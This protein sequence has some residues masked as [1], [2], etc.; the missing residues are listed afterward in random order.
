MLNSFFLNT[1]FQNIWRAL[2]HNSNQNNANSTINGI[3]KLSLRFSKYTNA[4][5]RPP[6]ARAHESHMKILAGDMLNIRNAMST[7]IIIPSS[8]VA[9][10]Q[11]YAKVITAMTDRTITI[12]PHASPSNPSVILIALT[13]AMVRKNVTIG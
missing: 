1:F 12:I 3:K 13:I 4:A 5:T 6:N 2:L 7:P 9:K 11:L 10:Y 8:A